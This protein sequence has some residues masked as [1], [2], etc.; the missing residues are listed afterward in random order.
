[1]RK[2]S[3]RHQPVAA[4]FLD[5][6]QV[7]H[8]DRLVKR[9]AENKIKHPGIQAPFFCRQL[10]QVGII[11][12]YFKDGGLHFQ[13]LSHGSLFHQ[14]AQVVVTTARFMLHDQF[15]HPLHLRQQIL[16]GQA[17]GGVH[18]FDFAGI[19]TIQY[20]ALQGTMGINAA[21]PIFVNRKTSKSSVPFGL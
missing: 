18:G 9:A 11:T 1:M 5:Q 12:H 20:P 19:P 17:L 10:P 8:A 21:G 6:A 13:L 14:M 16:A 7:K 2:L 4:V 3:R 15:P